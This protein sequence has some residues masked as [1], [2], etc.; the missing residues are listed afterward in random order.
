M[1]T[2]SFIVMVVVLVDDEVTGVGSFIVTDEPPPL[3]CRFFT[4][5]VL[6]RNFLSR[7]MSR[8]S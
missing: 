7:G 8:N 4:T 6:N 1:G 3:T 5:F 2:S